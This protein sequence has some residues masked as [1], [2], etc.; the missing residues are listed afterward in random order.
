L[1]S[2]NAQS[3]KVKFTH[4]TAR[5]G[6]SQSTVSC[7]MK[8]RSGF[9]WFGTQ[10]GLN[11]YDGYKFTIYRKNKSSNSLASDNIHVIYE[12]SR[13]V[14]WVGTDDGLSR[15]NKKDGSFT[16]YRT[17]ASDTGAISTNSITC[18]YED[19]LNNLWIGTYW[20]LNLLDRK[21]GKFKRFSSEPEDKFSISHPSIFT[22]YE[23]KQ[24]RLWIGTGDGLNLFDRKTFKARRYVHDNKN[25]NSIGTGAVSV[26]RETEDGQLLIGTKGSGLNVFDKSRKGFKHYTADSKN[27]NALS[28]NDINAMAYAG[29]NKLWVGTTNAL[30]YLDLNTGITKHYYSNDSD[31][32][33]LI[34]SSVTSINLDSSGILWVGTYDGGINKYDKN[35]S[36][37]DL[38]QYSAIDYQSISKNIVTSFAENVDGN[39]WIGTDGGG[40]NLLDKKTNKFQRFSPEPTNPNSMASYS[41]MTLYQKKN[42]PVLWIGYYGYG[43][44]KFDTETNTFKN[45]QKGTGENNLNDNNVYAIIEDSFGN[46]WIGTNGS[47]INVLNNKTQHITK[48]K[49]NPINILSGATVQ[50]GNIRCFFEDQEK[51]MWIGTVR[52]LSK[53]NPRTKKFTHY[54]I[55]NSNIGNDFIASIIS[56]RKGRIWI[57]TG[58]GGLNL[59]DKK[60]NK[61][62]VYNTD[63]GLPSNSINSV[64]EDKK[65]ILWISTNNGVCQFNPDTKSIKTYTSYNG[66]Q[67]LEFKV[68]SGLIAS[69]GEIYFGGANGFN[70]INPAGIAR[71]TNIPKVVIT[72]F[73]IFNKSIIP[74]AADSILKQSIEDTHLIRLPYNKNSVT[75]EFSALDFTVSDM[76]QYAYILEG[77]ETEWNKV[78]THRKATYTNLDPGKYTFKVKAANNDGV[79]SKKETSITLIIA[80]PFWKTWWS[81][82]F[83]LIFVYSV[84]I[85]MYKYRVRFIERQ[86]N[87]LEMLVQERTEELQAQTEELQAQSEELQAQSEELATQSEHLQTLNNELSCEKKAAELARLEAEKANQA[88]SIFLATMSHEIRTPMNGV[89][90]MASLLAQTKLDEEQEEYVKIINTSG[91]ALLGVIN[92]ILDFSKIESGNMEIEVHDFVLR[93]CIEDV[94]DIFGGKAAQIGIDLV[95]QIDH[96]LP[97]MIVGDSLRLRQ[98]L[99]NLISNAMKF[100]QRGEVFLKVGLNELT[101]EEFSI[102]FDVKDTGIGIPEDKLPRLF[103]A[104]SQVDSSTTRKYGGTGLGLAISER[105]VKLMGGNIG[106]SSQEGIGTTFHFTIKSKAAKSSEKQ[107]VNFGSDTE[108]KRILIVDDNATNL[109]ILKSQLE[110][111]KLVVIT[112]L[113]GKEALAILKK[114]TNYQ[115]VISDMQMPGMDGIGLAETIKKTL[116]A[117][118]IILLSSV[119]DESRSKYP[120]LFNSV[121]T[122]PIKQ[123]QLFK[124]VQA[125]LKQN[126]N[127][128]QEVKLKETMLSKDFALTYPLT[129]LI[130]EDHPINQK[131]AMRVLN[132]LGYKPEIANNGEEAVAMLHEKPYDVILMDMLMPEMDGLEATRIIRSSSL[133]QPQIVA[134]TANAMP[135]DREACLQAG[136]NDYISKPVKLD[137]L[138]DI[139]KKTAARLLIV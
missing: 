130:A 95:Y 77:F 37:F 136:M 124:L 131:L 121:L 55:S 133:K 19:R 41:V 39:I 88:K 128:V 118:P 10:D 115:L 43:L 101:E 72:D 68:A 70:L 73:Q 14:I 62:I 13:G 111:W 79:W 12:D 50:H 49:A 114:D 71:N 99:I 139:L 102:R 82:L 45:Y 25:P 38:Y 35:L 44:D 126:K 59:Y 31:R 16:N 112:A 89:I 46:T 83:V 134:M 119:G 122:K 32:S 117:I 103:T 52:G 87:E 33:T 4:L 23:D 98:I 22:I 76:N 36:C 5:D 54:N 113:S 15:F 57:G 24:G 138:M 11:R 135:E 34:N 56:D 85:G 27:P 1:S 91:D 137:I 51:N 106:V 48:L 53:Y 97:A 30:D 66:L 109:T 69:N 7:I 81:R 94:M 80:P 105:L 129:I 63:N 29:K 127:A 65:G 20:N 6:L 108:G 123:Q 40:L 67:S 75:F 17:N 58:G 116:P 28:D 18:I 120:H 96:R 84:I 21:T 92:D 100:T 74:G 8:D 110:I 86:K 61:F 42:S 90:G 64:V 107:Y 26:I 104:F 47:G 3:G 93:Q 132:K 78:G 9:M 2:V 60:T 125:E